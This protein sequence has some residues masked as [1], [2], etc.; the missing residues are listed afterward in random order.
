MDHGLS[1]SII[2][3]PIHFFAIWLYHIP[4]IFQT[5]LLFLW[6]SNMATWESPELNEGFIYIYSGNIIK[7]NKRCPPCLITRGHTLWSNID[8]EKRIHDFLGGFAPNRKIGLVTDILSP[9]YLGV[10][11]SKKVFGH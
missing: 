3:F 8:P 1:M 5:Q 7:L 2:I 10:S 9:W 6:Q 4:R 11:P